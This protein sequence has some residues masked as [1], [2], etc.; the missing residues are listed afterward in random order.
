MIIRAAAKEDLGAIMD[1]LE[2]AKGIMRA[3]GNTGQWV[4]G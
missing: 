3:S 2:A 4:N 1:V